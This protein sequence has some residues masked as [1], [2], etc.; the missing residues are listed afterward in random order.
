MHTTTN[1]AKSLDELVDSSGKQAGAFGKLAAGFMDY[2]QRHKNISFFAVHLLET[3]ITTS[4]GI[5]ISYYMPQLFSSKVAAPLII[6]TALGTGLDLLTELPVLYASTR[7]IYPADSGSFL[8]RYAGYEVAKKTTNAAVSG[9]LM[10][11]LLYSGIPLMPAM[12]LSGKIAAPITWIPN[13]MLY[14]GIVLKHDP[15]QPTLEMLQGSLAITKSIGSRALGFAYEAA[16]RTQQAAVDAQLAMKK[17]ASVITGRIYST[18]KATATVSINA[19]IAF[20]AALTTS[21]M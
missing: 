19:I 4:M 3:G 12:A 15:V 13:L 9:A 20:A 8:R 2:T 11:G 5:A 17:N 6:G 21:Q 1:R 10:T 18:V 14:H 7:D 16:D